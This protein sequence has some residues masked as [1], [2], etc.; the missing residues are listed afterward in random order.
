MEKIALEEHVVLD[1]EDHLD[2]WR[3]LVPM[4]P[5]PFVQRIIPQLTDISR[6]LERAAHRIRRP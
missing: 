5:E 6:R 1:R 3:T 2:R 4:I